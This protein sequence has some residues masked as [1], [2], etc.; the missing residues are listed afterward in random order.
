MGKE[1]GL[2]GHKIKLHNTMILY[3]IAQKATLQALEKPFL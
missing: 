1:S 3:T 2:S